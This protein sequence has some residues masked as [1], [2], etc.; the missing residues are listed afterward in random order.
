MHLAERLLHYRAIVGSLYRKDRRMLKVIA[1]KEGLRGYVSLKKNDLVQTILF[2]RTVIK[3]HVRYSGLH[4]KTIS[5]LRGEGSTGRMKKQMIEN[6]VRDRIEGNYDVKKRQVDWVKHREE[7]RPNL[8][9][10]ALNRTYRS[11]RLNGVEKTDPERYIQLVE[12]H[13]SRL[14]K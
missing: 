10:H 14:V 7:T 2:H 3:P 12:P 1:K 6:L 4:G 8:Y 9:D 11:F 13:I 5:E